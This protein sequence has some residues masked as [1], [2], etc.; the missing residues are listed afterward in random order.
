M[1][2]TLNNISFLLKS[3][4]S[5]GYQQ[6]QAIYTVG[7]TDDTTLLSSKT[8]VITIA[9]NGDLSQVQRLWQ[10]WISQIKANEGIK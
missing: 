10:S 2:K 1:A 9:N 3:D 8:G 5:T 6:C 7:S 4:G